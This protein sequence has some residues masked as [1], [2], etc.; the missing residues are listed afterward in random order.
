MRLHEAGVAPSLASS[1]SMTTLSRAFIF[2]FLLATINSVD[3][4]LT[5][6]DG[7][8]P[9]CSDGSALRPPPTPCVGGTGPPQC[10]DGSTPAKG[11]GAGGKTNGGGQQGGGGQGGCAT[12][13]CAAPLLGD[14]GLTTATG[15][16]ARSGRTFTAGENIYG[17]FEAGFST[18][19]DGILSRLG[20]NPG[21]LG[22]VDG[23]IDTYTAEQMV[24]HQC[25]VTLPRVEGND[26]ISLI[27]ECGGHTNEY[28]FHERLVC[29]YDATASGH[30]T[31]IG[32][33]TDDN[34]TP[35]YGKY[36]GTSTLPGNLDACGAHFGQTPDSNGAL[37]YHHHVQHQPPFTIG[38]F[39]P[40][41]SG[42]P[43]SLD[44]CR[45]LYNGANG[46]GGNDIVT[47]TTSTG[48]V[49]Y[50][51][52][53]PCY[54]STG[55]NVP[56]STSTTTTSPPPPPPPPPS[57]N[58]PS[59]TTTTASP[60][61]PPPYYGG[62]LPPPPTS[63]VVAFALTVSGDV[64]SYTP[65]KLDL[66]KG[67]LA[68]AAGV[69]SSDVTLTL[70]SASVRV[71]VAITVASMS[72]AQVVTATITPRIASTSA[73]SSLFTSTPITVEVV[74]TATMAALSPPAAPPEMRACGSSCDSESDV[75]EEGSVS[76]GGLSTGVLIAI[77]AGGMWLAV[78]AFYCCS[79]GIAKKQQGLS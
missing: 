40:S 44:E 60:P 49:Q 64:S 35:I 2:L 12:P 73:A 3:A 55:S 53:C 33:A 79:R 37:V 68:I 66:M 59:T 42:G 62:P 30:S 24:A 9:T 36:E 43:V 77:I 1:R 34:N 41:S 31:K 71:D 10:A 17:P 58:A 67:D 46:C 63:F 52:W 39:G 4:Q 38:C 76:G 26:Y 50:D 18:Q 51:K 75:E 47:V 13:P 78:V 6:G 45:A 54:D 28:H 5:C 7:S 25:G 21:S 29:L 11:N 8:T 20:C 23:G 48:S 56:N 65:S 27:D 70:T 19:Q 61:P 69:L 57:N 74:T 32:E 15:T 16:D 14:V 22:H 72:T